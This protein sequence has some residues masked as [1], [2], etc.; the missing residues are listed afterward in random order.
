MTKR[1]TYTKEFKLEAIEL[2]GR[3]GNTAQAERDLGIPSGQI[4]KWRTKLE[5]ESDPKKAFPGKGKVRDAEMNALKR[6]LARVEELKR[7]TQS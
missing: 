5:K 2:A 6:R 7:R 3:I 1:R 4:Y